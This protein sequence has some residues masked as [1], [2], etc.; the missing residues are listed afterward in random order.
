MARR[1]FSS[2]RKSFHRRGPSARRAIKRGLKAR[3]SSATGG[4]SKMLGGGVGLAI[5]AGAGLWWWSGR[6]TRQAQAAAIQQI[7]QRNAASAPFPTSAH[8]SMAATA[9]AVPNMIAAPTPTT[10]AGS[11]MSLFT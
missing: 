1:R 9:A 10:K 4:I 3:P 6:Q 7:A 11:I 2:Q 8:S 5:L